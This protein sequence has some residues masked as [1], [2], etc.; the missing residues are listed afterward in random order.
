MDRRSFLG[1]GLGAAALGVLPSELGAAQQS[2]SRTRGVALGGPLGVPNSELLKRV[3]F[4]KLTIDVGVRK[5]FKVIHCSDTHIALMNVS[6]LIGAKRT[7]DLAMFDYR[8]KEMQSAAGCFAAC[9][10]K[11]RLEN[12][13]LIHSGDMWDYHSEANFRFVQDALSAAGN[14]LCTVGN[15][16]IRGHWE[17]EPDIDNEGVRRRFESYLPNS[18]LF[19]A[20]QIGGV[21][22]VAFDNC[23]NW[24]GIQARLHTRLKAEFAKGLPTVLVMHKPIC[25]PDAKK[26]AL[27]VDHAKPDNLRAYLYA[28]DGGE[29]AFVDW[30]Y[31]QPNFKAVLC[32][33]CHYETQ[34]RLTDSVSQYSAGAAYQ[35][36]AYEIEFA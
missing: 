29:R 30:A 32:G 1:L 24:D 14:V 3:N 36:H 31:S 21:N 18:S 34:W 10:L 26:W 17:H 4:T 22:F 19:C 13:P 33:H 2:A 27:E 23:A 20:R 6:D 11:A 16:E 15:H 5:P 28:I 7:K 8:L 35:G 9:V 25:T 12:A